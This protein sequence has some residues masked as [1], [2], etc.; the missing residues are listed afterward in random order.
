MEVNRKRYI[1]FLHYTELMRQCLSL[2]SFVYI[3][4]KNK[5]KTKKWI[6]YDVHVWIIIVFI[7]FYYFLRTCLDFFFLNSNST[8][9]LFSFFF[10]NFVTNF[11]N[12][13]NLIFF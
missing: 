2:L 3:K 4:H 9:I 11:L 10:L 12:H 7:I 6:K 5:I 8:K 13:L 1:L